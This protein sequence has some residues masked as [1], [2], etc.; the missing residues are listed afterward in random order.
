[1]R[2]GFSVGVYGLPHLPA[3]DARRW[4]QMPHLSMSLAYLRDI[5]YY[6]RD[7]HIRMYR[8]HSALV[9]AASE[10]DMAGTSQIRECATELAA[11]GTL[12][13]ECDVRL[14]FHPYSAVVLNS[15]NEDQVARSVALLEGQAAILEA[16]QLGPE[17][18][19]VLHV[20]GVYDARATS[21]ERFIRRYEKLPRFI[22][23]RVA[24]ENDDHRFGHSD[25]RLV[26]QQCGVPLVYDHLHHLV[27]NHVCI[28]VPEALSYSLDTWP[29]QTSPKVHFS[30]P[31]TEMG[32]SE[33]PTR[34]KLPT[35]T[36]HSDFVNPF[37]FADFVRMAAGLRAFDIMLEAKARDIA[38][39]K[40]R[41]DLKK[42]APDVAR[43]VW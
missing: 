13:R 28:P 19:I 21:R 15:P 16:M 37:D 9:P 24:L 4:P 29:Q 2:L 11:L 32:S 6:L 17:A 31:R 20:V 10:G 30:T 41:E 39:L 22:Q 34:F 8:M 26:H 36:E 5:L 42:F 23:S 33:N 43:L 3:H 27:C 7:K 35:W 38:L 12:A 40:L 18:V 1:M 14:S 25:V